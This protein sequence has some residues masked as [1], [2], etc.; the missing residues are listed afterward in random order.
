MG[1]QIKSFRDSRP[2]HIP[3]YLRAA[4]TRSSLKIIAI[5]MSPHIVISASS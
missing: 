4:I 3:E 5:S 2:E 1:Q